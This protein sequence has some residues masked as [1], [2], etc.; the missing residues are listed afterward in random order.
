MP[1]A[2]A[3]PSLATVRLHY[4][5]AGRGPAGR[6]PA[7]LPGVLVRLAA[8][9]RAAR[10]GRLPRRRARPARL[11]P[12]AQAARASRRTTSTRWRATS[13][14]LIRERGERRACVA[15][16]DWGGAVAWATAMFHPEVVERLAILNAPHPR[17]FLEAVRR[18]APAREVLV[19]AAFPAAVA[20]RAIGS[21]GFRSAFLARRAARRVHAG[22]P[23][24]LRG[25]LGAARRADRVAQLLPRALA[26]D[27]AGRGRRIRPDRGARRG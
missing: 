10:G 9:D 7:R 13:R 26:H 6:A 20:A 18:P 23:R 16:H 25:G 4:V 8:P 27:A 24:A 2:T 5:E 11:Q 19:H 22:G 15:G 14:D 3:T 1:C 21:R 12:L 17:R